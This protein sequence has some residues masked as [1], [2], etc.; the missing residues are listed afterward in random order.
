MKGTVVSKSALLTRAL[1][2]LVPVSFA[3]MCLAKSLVPSA[4]DMDKDL[5]EVTIPKLQTFYTQHRY[6]VTQV[7]QWHLDRIRRYNGIYR[8]LETVLEAE[9]L[10]AAAQED[11]E[12]AQG[13]GVRGP[14]FGVPTVLKENT[15]IAGQV[16]TDGW[17]GF[18]IPYPAKTTEP[19]MA[20]SLAKLAV[21]SGA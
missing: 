9:A 7:V 1:L 6:T 3:A 16:T 5:L 2:G 13:N 4:L 12:L 20:I 8:A 17:S 10:A 18:T 11:A 21:A 14:L 19:P 15:S